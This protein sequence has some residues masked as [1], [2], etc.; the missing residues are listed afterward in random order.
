VPRGL[1]VK[2]WHYME[3]DLSMAAPWWEDE[4][5]EGIALLEALLEK[6]ARFHAFLEGRP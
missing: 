1:S 3:A 6:H 4:A 2:G 5:E